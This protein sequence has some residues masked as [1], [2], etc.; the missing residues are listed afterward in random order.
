M[1]VSSITTKLL[2]STLILVTLTPFLI[3]PLV[4][5]ILGSVQQQAMKSIEDDAPS[6]NGNSIVE[7]LMEA[8]SPAKLE[9]LSKRC[10]K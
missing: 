5:N 3:L 10:K 6:L 4:L 2:V 7:E 9:R 1:P 8:I